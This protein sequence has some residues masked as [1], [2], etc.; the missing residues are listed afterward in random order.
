M[1][2]EDNVVTVEPGLYY[3]RARRGIPSGGIRI[4]D[5]AVVTGRGC[6]RITRFPKDIKNAVL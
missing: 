1:L 2:E 4:E 5:M 6:R 3:S